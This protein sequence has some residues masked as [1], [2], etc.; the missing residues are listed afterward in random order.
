M[1]KRGR[2][3]RGQ[4]REHRVVVVDVACGCAGKKKDRGWEDDGGRRLREVL[5]APCSQRCTAVCSA[6]VQWAVCRCCDGLEGL[7]VA[8][9]V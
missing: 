5:A 8:E 7:E 2:R 1:R 3:A 4:P 6:G 9:W